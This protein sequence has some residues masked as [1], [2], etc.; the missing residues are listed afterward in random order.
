VLKDTHILYCLSAFYIGAVCVL[1]SI[2]ISVDI[3]IL[4]TALFGNVIS[5][6][7]WIEQYGQKTTNGAM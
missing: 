4:R 6:R 5:E 7:E 2:I 3:V 1:Q